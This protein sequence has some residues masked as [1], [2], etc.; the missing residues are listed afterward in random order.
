M[1]GLLSS[2]AMRADVA[3]T[4]TLAR[5]RPYHFSAMFEEVKSLHFLLHAAS[6]AQAEPL[7]PRPF[8]Y[9][10]LLRDS[11]RY[12]WP[13]STPGEAHLVP[14]WECFTWQTGRRIGTDGSVAKA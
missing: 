9:P 6:F 12:K 3:E 10:I 4:I 11:R 8:I 14:L 7:F 2:N 1:E 5:L 13:G